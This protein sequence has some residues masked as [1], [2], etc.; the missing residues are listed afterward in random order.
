MYWKAVP[1]QDV[2][3]PVN[4]SLFCFMYDVPLLL[5][6]LCYQFILHTIGP[7]DFLHRSAGPYFK[8]FNAFSFYFP[9]R[10]VFRTYNAMFQIYPNVQ[11]KM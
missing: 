8:I 2:T 7:T 11:P 3:N 4:V 10:L 6:F 9:K 5:D 1:T